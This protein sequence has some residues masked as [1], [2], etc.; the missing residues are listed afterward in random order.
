MPSKGLAPTIREHGLCSPYVNDAAQSTDGIG[1]EDGIS[2]A[3]SILHNRA[4]HH[5]NIF[6]GV[7]ELLD[8]KVD[9][10][11]E[12]GIFIL[13]ELRDAEE[14]GRRFI[15]REVLAGV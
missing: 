12:A 15:G 9:H 3:S 7:G 6:S 2:A 4:C 14:E 10:L 8:D 1:P 11:T 13:E 5:D